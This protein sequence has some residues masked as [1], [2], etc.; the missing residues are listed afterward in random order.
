MS[1]GLPAR[2]RSRSALWL[3][4]SVPIAVV[5]DVIL[6]GLARFAWCGFGRCLYPS[7]AAEF[8]LTVVLTGSLLGGI[9]LVT[10]LAVALP[11]WIPGRRRPVIAAAVGLAA[12]AVACAFVFGR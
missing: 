6:T 7:T 9:L 1:S 12:V 8:T 5:V 4:G 11:P 10:W 3:L 2:Q